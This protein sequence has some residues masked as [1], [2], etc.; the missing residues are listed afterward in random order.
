[1]ADPSIKGS[2]VAPMVEEILDLRERGR[3]SAEELEGRLGRDALALLERKVDPSAWIPLSIYEQLALVL[4]VNE[5]GSPE[6]YMRA[7][8]ERAGER[9]ASAGIYQQ[10]KFV[11]SERRT[12]GTVETFKTDMRL[13][14]SI[15]AALLNVGTWTVEDDPE[16]DGRV[17]VVVREARDI[18]DALARA[19]EGFFIGISRHGHHGDLRWTLER[20]RRAEFRLR[21]DRDVAQLA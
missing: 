20:P 11:A 17:M 2:I 16:H 4:Q 13:I 15:Q 14:L 7:R 21:M 9:L 19:I 10:L 5:G 6:A 3:I 1:M 8:G 18:P 12:I